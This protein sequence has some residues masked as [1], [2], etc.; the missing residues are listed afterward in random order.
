MLKTARLIEKI[1]EP[2]Q[3]KPPDGIG[4]EFGDNERPGLPVT[5][6]TRIVRYRAVAISAADPSKKA[7]VNKGD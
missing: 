2:D 4:H 7:E 1:G 5:Q 3:E 6:Q